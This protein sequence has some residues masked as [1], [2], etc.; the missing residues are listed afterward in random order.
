M[1]THCSVLA[2]RIPG[3]GEPG[4]LPSVGSHR[5]GHDWSDLA[6]AADG[7]ILLSIFCFCAETCYSFFYFKLLSNVIIVQ[8]SMF[9][10]V[11][12]KSLSDNSNISVISVLASANYLF[13]FKLRFSWFLASW[14]I[15]NC[16]LDTSGIVLWDWSVSAGPLSYCSAG[17]GGAGWRVT[18]WLPPGGDKSPG[19]PCSRWHLRSGGHLV[20]AG[21]EQKFSNPARSLLIP[22]WCHVTPWVLR[23]LALALPFRCLLYLWCSGF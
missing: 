14:G 6:A 7:M 15:L 21:P 20:I 13:S 3:M 16:I 12:F 4:G 22:P 9:M 18:S 10:P 8:W 17:A 23:S 1:A 19:S 5:D 11:V 2:W